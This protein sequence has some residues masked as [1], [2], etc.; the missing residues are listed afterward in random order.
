MRNRQCLCGFA[1][2]QMLAI[3]LIP[4]RKP[5]HNKLRLASA[6]KSS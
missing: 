1:R 2:F 3:R 5:R 6:A 4:P